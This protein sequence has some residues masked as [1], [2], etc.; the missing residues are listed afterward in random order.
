MYDDDTSWFPT[1]V[2]NVLLINGQKI[3][4][5]PGAGARATAERMYVDGEHLT[6]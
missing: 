1:G 3:V 2:N 5:W 6:W 4:E